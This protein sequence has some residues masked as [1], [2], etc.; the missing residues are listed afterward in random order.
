M[1]TH[2]DAYRDTYR[3]RHTRALTQTRGHIQTQT[4]GHRHTQGR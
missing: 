3:H 4:H 2:V 1:N